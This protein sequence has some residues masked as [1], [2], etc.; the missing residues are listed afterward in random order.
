MHLSVEIGE[1]Y[2]WGS[3]NDGQ[4]GTDV[5]SETAQLSKVRLGEKIL[6]ICCG[7]YHTAAVTGLF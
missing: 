2:T 4:L 5:K 7:Y 3:N 1:V 6:H